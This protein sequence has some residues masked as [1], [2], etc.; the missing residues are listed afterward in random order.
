MGRNLSNYKKGVDAEIIVSNYLI[1]H[2]YKIIK[3]RYKTEYGEIDLIANKEK[4]LLFVG[5]KNRKVIS[6]HEIINKRQKKRCC[7]AAMYFLS[8]NQTFLNFTMRFDCFFI[9]HYG[10]FK[11]IKNAWEITESELASVL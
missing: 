5:V 9:N 2:G 1:Q 6:D 3:H 11:H 4:L 10:K 7:E 8:Q